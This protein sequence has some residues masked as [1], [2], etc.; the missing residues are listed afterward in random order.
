MNARADRAFH[1]VPGD[2]QVALASPREA[3]DDRDVT[4]LVDVAAD[5]EGNGPDGLEV[6]GGGYRETR[7][8]DV[9]AELGELV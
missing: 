1:C 5:V 2:L 8:D 4:R 3:A 6:V 9:D 7:L